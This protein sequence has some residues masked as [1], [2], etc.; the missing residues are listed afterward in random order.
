MKKAI[1]AGNF[2]P[3]TNGHI[4]IIKR[5]LVFFDEINIAVIQNINKKAFFTIEER[6]GFIKKLF[7]DRASVKVESFDGLLVNYAQEKKIYTLIRGLRAVSDFDYEFQMAL[8]NRKLNS[9]LD[10]IFL[11]TDEKYSYLSSSLVK[12]L[13]QFKIDL[14]KFVP[15][16][17]QGA[18][19]EKFK[20][21]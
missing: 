21:G 20:N 17:I 7:I 16:I 2:D 3:I 6:M 9:K 18:L 14:K 11:M 5:A 13:A 1:Y 4:D 12:E 10:T 19:K 8:M 15:E